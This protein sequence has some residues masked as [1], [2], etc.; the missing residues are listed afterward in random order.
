[1]T[2]SRGTW[3]WAGI[4][5]GGLAAATLPLNLLRLILPNSSAPPTTVVVTLRDSV[6]RAQAGDEGRHAR[7]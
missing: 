5:L 7:A 3:Y 4:R 6:S 2:F 1:M